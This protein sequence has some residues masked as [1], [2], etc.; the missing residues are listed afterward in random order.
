MD[1]LA[2]STEPA[3]DPIAYREF[4]REEQ[5]NY[6]DWL[7]NSLHID[8]HVSAYCYNM[9]NAV[10]NTTGARDT[11]PVVDDMDSEPPPLESDDDEMFSL[12][13]PSV[14]PEPPQLTIQVPRPWDKEP[15]PKRARNLC[16]CCLDRAKHCVVVP[17]GHMCLCVACAITL[18]YTQAPQCPICRQAATMI[19]RV[20]K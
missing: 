7:R 2:A 12:E 8:E 9:F 3:D 14:T 18:G 4:T 19:I 11:V 10:H 20:W 16:V 1:P 6:A 17:C 13:A 15:R 5:D